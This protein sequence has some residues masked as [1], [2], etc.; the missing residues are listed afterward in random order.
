MSAVPEHVSV[1]TVTVNPALDVGLS[2]S[3]LIPEHKLRATDSRRDPG[4][5]GVNVS[6]VLRRLGVESASW[7]AVGGGIG[8]EYVGLLR[9]EG[10]IPLT[11]EIDGLTRES[12][13]VFDEAR[14]LQYRIVVDGPTIDDPDAMSE[15]I[16]AAAA[17]ADVVVLSGGTAP[18]LPDRFYADLIDVIAETH[19]VTTVVDTA[20]PPLAEVMTSAAT[21]V[22][23]SRR[24]L[25]SMVDWVPADRGEI[26]LAARQVLERGTVGA[27]AVSLGAEGAM[28]ARPDEE[29]VWFGAP[30][31]EQVVSTVGSGDSM[32]AGMV[33]A[34][35]GGA[36]L[37]DAVRRGVAAGSAAVLTPG[38]DL[39][40]PADVERLY[41]LVSVE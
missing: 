24:E 28:L 22:K 3:T 19:G 25:A 27:L 12:F 2:V 9:D 26:A 31:V 21:L 35:I 20:G 1:L 16:I 32:V 15:A 30:P 37:V 10:I 8:D 34:L 13:A 40:H 5:G 41:H 17:G 29:P 14:L 38:T 39:C 36:D 7:V 33:A 23:P 6:R 18:G 4:G 11:Y